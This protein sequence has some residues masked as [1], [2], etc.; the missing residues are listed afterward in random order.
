M[1]TGFSDRC[2][3]QELA[4]TDLRS[5]TYNNAFLKIEDG[6]TFLIDYDKVVLKQPAGLYDTQNAEAERAAASSSSTT[7]SQETDG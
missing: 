6:Y 1:F 4:E 2:Y 7:S 5:E 3:W